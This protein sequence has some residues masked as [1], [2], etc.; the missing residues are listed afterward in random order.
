MTASSSTHDEIEL[1]KLPVCRMQDVLLSRMIARQE[2]ARLGFSPQALTQIATA[3]SEIAR[4]VVQHARSSG[5]LRIVEIADAGRP[6]L[7][8]TVEDDGIG[9]ADVSGALNGTTPGAG[10]PG[11]K[12]LMDS[13]AIRSEAG[14][15]TAVEMVK[16]LPTS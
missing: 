5:R 11:C 12:K 7:K 15:G 9:I 3:V 2:G 13:F 16:W 14:M 1:A 10:I 4:N 8:I 6:G